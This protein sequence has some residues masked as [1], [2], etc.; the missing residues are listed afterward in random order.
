MATTT[1]ATVEKAFKDFFIEPARKQLDERSGPFLAQMEKSTKEVSGKSIKMPLVY[2][3]S[4]G[5]GNRAENGTLPSSS[6]RKWDMAE[7]DTKNIYGTIALTGKSIKASRNEQGAFVR[8]LKNQMQDLT[9]DANNDLRRQLFGDGTGTMATLVAQG[10]LNTL[11]VSTTKYFAVGQFVDV[12]DVND[13]NAKI[14]ATDGVEILDVDKIGSK[15]TISGT[16]VTVEAGDFITIHDNLNQELTG[17]D[18]VMT[19]NNTLY[20]I[21]R[22]A[23]K[24][25]NPNVLGNSG[26]LRD[27]DELLMQQAVDDADENLGSQ[28]DFIMAGYGVARGFQKNQLSYKKNIEY[29]TI[30]GGYDVMKFGKIPVT[31]EKFMPDN[32]MDFMVKENWK[33]YRMGAWDWMQKDGAILNRVSGKD[34]YEATL[35]MYADIGC[36]KPGG[37]TRLID[38]NE[39]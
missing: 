26:T 39:E 21:D 20:G 9:K 7:W 37:Q 24:W 25:F 5:V 19:A 29:M 34:A 16:A 27:V 23:N 33:M 13:S 28:V 32:T 10:P 6:P 12:L 4:G 8:L 14:T 15:I 2:G 31:R 1:I 35:Y 11:A 38:L 17:T 36:D 30:K 18:K 22:S 3:R